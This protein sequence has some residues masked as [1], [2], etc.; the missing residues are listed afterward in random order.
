MALNYLITGTSVTCVV[1]LFD[2]VLISN[3]IFKYVLTH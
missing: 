2:L 3:V 1:N